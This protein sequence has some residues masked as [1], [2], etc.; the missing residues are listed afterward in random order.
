M[1]VIESNLGK[2]AV[3]VRQTV[4]HFIGSART[5]H[6]ELVDEFTGEIEE[7]VREEVLAEVESMALG[8][9]CPHGPCSAARL[10]DQIELR[11]VDFSQ[12]PA[13]AEL[14]QEIRSRLGQ[15]EWSVTAAKGVGEEASAI[16]IRPA[17]IHFA[18]YEIGAFNDLLTDPSLSCH[19]EG[20]VLDGLWAGQEV[21][22]EFHFAPV[23]PKKDPGPG[24]QK[25]PKA[26]MN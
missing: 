3:L 8:E 25:V 5:K 1:S 21:H 12:G 24:P 15:G 19:R 20:A 4:D 2:L 14:V 22:V 10:E 6:P 13:L 26:M 16:I 9:F 7:I 17:G 18:L 11:L 23:Q